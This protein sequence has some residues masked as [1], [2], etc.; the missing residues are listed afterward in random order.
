VRQ[1]PKTDQL[2]RKQRIT[3]PQHDQT[4]SPATG[5]DPIG[6]PL[7]ERTQRN[8][9][10]DALD[11]RLEDDPQ[12]CLDQEDDRKQNQKRLLVARIM[13]H[14]DPVSAGHRSHMDC[15]FADRQARLP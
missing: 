15:P 8:P 9:R 14:L 4:S 13:G 2:E 12:P 6:Q 5:I 3:A 10:D 1:Q 11:D 7:L